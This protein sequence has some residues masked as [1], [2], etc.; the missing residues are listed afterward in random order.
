MESYKSDKIS[1]VIDPGHGGEDNGASHG[2]VDED[3]INLAIA[4]YLGY[5]L[6]EAG[7]TYAM[8]R[9]KDE[10]VS[11]KQRATFA[12]MKS[13]DLFI[14]IHCDAFHKDTAHGMTVHTHIYPSLNT[15]RASSI[16]NKQLLTYF[17]LHRNRGI[18]KSNFYVLR[19]TFCPAVLVECEFLSNPDTRKFLKKPENQKRMAQCLKRGMTLYLQ[20]V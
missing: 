12:N 13:P 17:P 8:T 18:K 11:L 1:V 4:C 14:S 16:I 15:I 3:D 20:E 7:I 5:E 10:Y 19:K 2:Y 9:D 6:R